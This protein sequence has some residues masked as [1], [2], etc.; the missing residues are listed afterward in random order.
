M[1]RDP[2]LGGSIDSSR[3]LFRLKEGEDKRYPE[4]SPDAAHQNNRVVEQATVE[5]SNLLSTPTNEPSN[6]LSTPTNEPSNSNI[7]DGIGMLSTSAKNEGSNIFDG[8]GLM[9]VQNTTPT[10]PKTMVEADRVLNPEL[11]MAGG[12]PQESHSQLHEKARVAGV[13]A[14]HIKSALL[15]PSRFSIQPFAKTAI[16]LIASLKLQELMKKVISSIRSL[17]SVM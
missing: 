2:G 6:L 12:T 11:E 4:L 9:A 3:D 14:N 10:A 8:I 17:F 13:L 5:P 1:T 15:I 7:F 16:S